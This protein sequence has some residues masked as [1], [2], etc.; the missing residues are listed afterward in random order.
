MRE[1]YVKG[2]LGKCMLTCNYNFVGVLLACGALSNLWTF[3]KLFEFSIYENWIKLV[4]FES[5]VFPKQ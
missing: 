1:L 4:P 5:I 3:I 2:D